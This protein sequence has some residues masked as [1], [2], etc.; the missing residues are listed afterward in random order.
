MLTLQRRL[1]VVSL[2]TLLVVRLQAESVT[3]SARDGQYRFCHQC[4]KFQPL[5]AF[6][7]VKRWVDR[8]LAATRL[9]SPSG[10]K[11]MV[12]CCCTLFES[13][14]HCIASSNFEQLQ[15][16]A[17]PSAATQTGPQ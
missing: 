15:P 17:G 13:I 10:L 14:R 16:M 5:T 9:A 7:G 11:G 12:W 1:P 8:Q 6:D 3:L 2:D 4:G